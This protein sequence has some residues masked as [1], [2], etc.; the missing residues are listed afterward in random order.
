MLRAGG[1]LHFFF[2]H[3]EFDHVVAFSGEQGGA[4]HGGEK[5]LGVD[6]QVVVERLRDD[7]FGDGVVARDQARA[8]DGVVKEEEDAGIRNHQGN[9]LRTFKHVGDVGENAG[10]DVATEADIRING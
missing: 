2:A 5:L 10:G 1:N 6:F 7:G 8:D 3:G 4:G 9:L